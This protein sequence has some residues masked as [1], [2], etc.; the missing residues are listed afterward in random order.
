MKVK[1]IHDHGC[2]D[3]IL[4]V[5]KEYE[6]A[7]DQW[8]GYDLVGIPSPWG[9]WNKDRFDTMATKVEVGQVWYNGRC[10][11]N[12][13][14]RIAEI[15]ESY[16]HGAWLLNDGTEKNKI[17]SFGPLNADGTPNNWDKEWKLEAVPVGVPD[18]SAPTV[19][20]SDADAA[21]T[22]KFFQASAHHDVCPKCAAPKPCSYHP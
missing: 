9:P 1:C 5:G 22:F 13:R 4:V 21:K 11:T 20:P 8:N 10:V 12:C 17:V 14:I 2:A 6:V 18:T 19:D 3:G 15:K 16:A 7:H